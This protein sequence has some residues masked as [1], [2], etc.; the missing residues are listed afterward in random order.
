MKYKETKVVSRLEKDYNPNTKLF[1]VKGGGG[2]ASP[3]AKRRK[4]KT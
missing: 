3:N 1:P 2:V 4:N